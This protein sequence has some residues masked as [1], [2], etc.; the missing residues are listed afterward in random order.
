MG[1]N[2]VLKLLGEYG[3]DCPRSIRAA[4]VISP[5]VDLMK[6][7]SVLDRPSNV[8]YR[9]YY[10]Q[11]LRRLSMRSPEGLAP[12][13]KPEELRKVRTIR[14]FDE[15]VTAPLAGFEDAFHYYR[16]V[17][18]IHLLPSIR[19]PTLLLHSKDDPLLPWE[20]LQGF[21]GNTNQFLHVHLTEKGGHA[22]F[23]GKRKRGDVDQSWAE[24]RV[25]DFLQRWVSPA[26]S[27]VTRNNRVL[28][29]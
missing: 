17:S 15:V 23:I 6:S 2:I 9:L 22:A 14:Q 11:R 10:L 19:L 12:F 18:S 8:L 3:N 27:K 26:E 5:L 28:Q 25:I 4:A 7:W 16:K 24:N 21:T 20:P 1:G 13:I 29:G